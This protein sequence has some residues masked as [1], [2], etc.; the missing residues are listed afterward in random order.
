MNGLRP[1]LAAVP[2]RDGIERRQAYLLQAVLF[3]VATVFLIATTGNALTNLPRGS[4]NGV[5]ANLIAGLIALA[6]IG[7]L[8]RGQFRLVAGLTVGLLIL[9]FAHGLASVGFAAGGP[10]LALLLVP[11]VLA[12]LILPRVWLLITAVA[13]YVAA[14]L[15]VG[16]GPVAGAS[17]APVSLSN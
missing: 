7:V 10:F 11:L 13:A 8:R 12:G 6:L 15:A 1:W 5:F 17:D 4:T 2:G 9:G 3:G 16:Y 14:E